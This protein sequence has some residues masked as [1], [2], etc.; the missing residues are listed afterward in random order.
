MSEAQN[1]TENEQEEEVHYPYVVRGA[2]IYCTKGSHKRKL[3]MPA[4]H[5]SYIRDKA[6]MN[7]MDC[8]VGI[9]QNIPPFGACTS[10]EKDGI[11]IKIEDEK[12]A[13]SYV[14]EE[15]N[16]VLPTMPIEGKLCEPEL[17]KE[18]L[19]AQEETLVD[20]KPAITANCTITCKYGGTIGFADAGQDVY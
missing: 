18:W 11:D 5:G 15:G 12:D 2:T 9:D 13:I 14:D 19:D 20:G 6:M 3:D 1:N 7:K 8:K 4:S 10:E 17:L 16:E